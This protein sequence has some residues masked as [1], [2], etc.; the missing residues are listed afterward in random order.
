MSPK[1]TE[2]QT[3]ITSEIFDREISSDIFGKLKHVV[4]WLDKN[5]FKS[6]LMFQN[7]SQLN[8]SYEIRYKSLLPYK[9]H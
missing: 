3:E 1:V 8:I 6:K 4:A 7:G 5:T 2:L 9:M